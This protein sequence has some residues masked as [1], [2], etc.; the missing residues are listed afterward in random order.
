MWYIRQSTD[1][2]YN[3]IWYIRFACCMTMATDSHQEYIVYIAFPMQRNLFGS[4]GSAVLA[5][6]VNDWVRAGWIVVTR[7]DGNL[8]LFWSQTCL[9]R[10][11]DISPLTVIYEVEACVVPF[12]H[13][14]LI[15]GDWHSSITIVATSVSLLVAMVLLTS[16]SSISV[17]KVRSL[18][19]C[20][21][22]NSAFMGRSV[23]S[24]LTMP[25]CQLE[26]YSHQAAIHI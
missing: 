24:P 15:L 8:G 18:S 25:C 3:L 20:Q 9:W 10:A 6:S 23:G 7:P 17:R 14:S 12:I 2:K 26:I 19:S 5:W 21:C 4:H 13:H 1:D 11:V 22:G 16:F